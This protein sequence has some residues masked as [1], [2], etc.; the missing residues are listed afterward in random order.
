MEL[1]TTSQ[2]VKA[3]VGCLECRLML[4]QAV[5][6]SM[7]YR[8]NIDHLLRHVAFPTHGDTFRG[9]SQKLVKLSRHPVRVLLCAYIIIGHLDILFSGQSECETTLAESAANIIGE[10]ELLIKIII[11]DCRTFR[12]QLEAFDS[13]WYFYLHHFVDWKSKDAKLL[14]RDLVRAAGQLELSTTGSGNASK[15][16]MVPSW[17]K[18][19][20]LPSRNATGVTDRGLSLNFS[21]NELL[22]N[23]IIHEHQSRF[24]EGLDVAHEDHNSLKARVRETME[25]AFWNGVLE[26]M[27]NDK[28][29]FRDEMSSQ[30]WRKEISETIDVDILEQILKLGAVDMA[31]L[32]SILEFALI[33]L[34]KL[35]APA[36]DEAMTVLHNKIL[37]ELGEVPLPGDE[38]K[39][40]YVLS[41][42][43]GLCFTLQE[44]QT[45]KR[46]I[47]RARIKLLEPVIRGPA[48]LE[49]LKMAFANRH[50]PPGAV[51]S[52]LPLTKQWLSSVSPDVEQ[53]WHEHLDYLCDF[54]KDNDFFE[55]LFPSTLRSGGTTYSVPEIRSST[56]NAGCLFLLGLLKLVNRV[57]GLTLKDLP[58]TLK[59]NMFT[60]RT[61]QLQIQKIIQLCKLLDGVEEVRLSDII[62]KING[63][64]KYSR[65]IMANMLAKSLQAGD[66]V[67]RHV[68]HSIYL[69]LRGGVFG[70]TG[71][72]KRRLVEAALRLV[73]A[74]VL[75]NRVIKAAKVLI[76]IASVSLS[77]NQEWYKV[78]LETCNWNLTIYE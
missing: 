10:F 24:A 12:S 13:A 19:L 21:E 63:T 20:T 60:L 54:T 48:G 52:S 31:H 28:S 34:R 7:C 75:A 36:N 37:R 27:K 56:S 62:E 41:I 44:I 6:G 68:S 16:K 43:K 69:A 35:S 14:E 58:K 4:S 33:T 67:Y 42:I 55:I 2:T 25:K 77:V 39:V 45:L 46:E 38:S 72:N 5:I 70:G 15:D 26:S 64:L 30:P 66:A 74:A 61:V 23:E 59:L 17:S 32:R 1:T 49:Y 47:S 18:E 22:V 76:V 78:M 29:D 51:P 11:N 71:L 65:T 9:R 3:F 57:E 50:R 8:A 73:G 40:P 53:E